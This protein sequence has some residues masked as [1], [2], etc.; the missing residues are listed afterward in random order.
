MNKKTVRVLPSLFIAIGGAIG[1]FSCYAIG[2]FGVAYPPAREQIGFLVGSI[3]IV[4]CVI[5]PTTGLAILVY[6]GYYSMITISEKGIE[7]ALFGIFMKVK[8]TWDEVKWMK[9][10]CRVIDNIFISSKAESETMTFEQAIKRRDII[11]IA[12]SKKTLKAIRQYTDK[13]IINLSEEQIQSMFADK[14]SK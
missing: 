10:M 2:I 5:V 7:R 1:M 3:L 12:V 13:E 11:Q 8:I 4:M 9:H 6:R 14:K